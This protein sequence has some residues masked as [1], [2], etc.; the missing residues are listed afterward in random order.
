MDDKTYSITLADG[1]ILENLRLNG[2]NFI[3]AEP[4]DKSIFENNCCPVTIS[5]GETSEIHD[6]MAF[7]QITKH[8]DEY[9]LVLRDLSNRE[10]EDIKLRS[11]V[12]YLAMMTGIDL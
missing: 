9:W 8:S 2:N 3:S 6:N 5:D 10:L 1:T 11:D 7:V 12:E 4:I